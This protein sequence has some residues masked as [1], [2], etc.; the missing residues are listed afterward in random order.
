[1]ADIVVLKTL[2]Y[3]RHY[4]MADIMVWQTSCRQILWY[5]MHHD[6]TDIMVWQLPYTVH[7]I[8]KSSPWLFPEMWSTIYNLIGAP[9]L[10]LSKVRII[11]IFTNIYKYLQILILLHKCHSSTLSHNT[12]SPMVMVMVRLIDYNKLSIS[13]IAKTIM[14]PL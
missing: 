12:K 11:L 9:Y 4:C 3:D 14:T 2:W 10:Q 8:R 13:G 7:D 1:M 6:M 5:G